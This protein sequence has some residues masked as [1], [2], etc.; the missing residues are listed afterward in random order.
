MAFS[1]CT[2][3]TRYGQAQVEQTGADSFRV[4]I[5]AAEVDGARYTAIAHLFMSEPGQFIEFTPDGHDRFLMLPHGFTAEMPDASRFASDLDLGLATLVPADDLH[6]AED[7]LREATREAGCKAFDRIY[8]LAEDLS[9]D[10]G[11]EPSFAM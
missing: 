3:P 5:E 4:S 10:A 7:K 11:Y 2:V 8:G 9:R 1:H 6:S